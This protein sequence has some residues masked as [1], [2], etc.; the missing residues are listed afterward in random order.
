MILGIFK[1]NGSMD[2]KIHFFT[3]YFFFFKIAF[4]L[5]LIKIGQIF[6]EVNFVF[7]P[8]FFSHNFKVLFSEISKICRT[9]SKTTK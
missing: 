4:L 5:V 2:R 3:K 9:H 8:K 6:L 1:K 7:S